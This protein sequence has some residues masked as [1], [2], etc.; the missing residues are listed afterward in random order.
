M[1]A[2]ALRKGEWP[3]LGEAMNALP[4]NKWRNFVEFLLL[5]TPGYGAQ[6]NAARRAGFGR[7]NTSPINMARISTRLMHDPR[8]QAAI[9]E[10]SRKMLRSGAPEAVKAVYA[11]IRNPDHKDH[12]RFVAM[13]LD[14]TDPTESRQFVQVVHKSIDPDQE[15]LE[16]LRAARQLG[17]PR[18]K[19]LE[20]YG[21]NG[22]DRLERLEAQDK[23]KRANE[24][25]VIDGVAVETRQD[26]L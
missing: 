24:A 20:L 13:L 1:K 8:V 3:Q 5:E 18:E 2:L 19:L 11:G 22:L 21:V 23:F 9:A 15:A 26:G 14:R 16:E 25:K 10:E 4:N 6:T 7:V 12:A 17:A